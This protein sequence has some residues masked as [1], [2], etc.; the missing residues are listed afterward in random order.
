[1]RLQT[2]AALRE[3]WEDADDPTPLA[4]TA[5]DPPALN[6]ERLLRLLMR[7][8]REVELDRQADRQAAQQAIQDL[9]QRVSALELKVG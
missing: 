9:R 8:L 2:T 6:G 4:R 3:Y 1:M 5:A 7:A